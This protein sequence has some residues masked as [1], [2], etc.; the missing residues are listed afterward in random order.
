MSSA[1]I[2]IEVRG[3]LY[4]KLIERQKTA[5]W[6]LCL[7][8]AN[9]NVARAQDM[10]QEVW[11]A[12]WRYF[13][14]LRPDCT[15]EQERKWVLLRA[16]GILY[17]REQDKSPP[18]VFMDTLPETPVETEERDER[19]LVLFERLD[20]DD[21]LLMQM[22]LDGYSFAEIGSALGIS[23]AAANMRKCRIVSQ[24]KRWAKRMNKQ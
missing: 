1:D 10:V 19:L 12:L 22:H 9:Y 2:D 15:E 6:G 24:L 18:L 20:A 4:L 23:A 21:R 11:M 14:S 8:R 7:R 5:V 3:E 16:R 17:Y 13:G